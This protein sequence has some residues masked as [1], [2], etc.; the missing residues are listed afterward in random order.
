MELPKNYD[1][2][3]EEPRWQK[4]W[5]EKDIFVFDPK[6]Q[7][8]AYTIDTPPP[9]VSG[10][11]HLGHAF[12]Y[13]QEDFIAR[14]Q[15]MRGKNVYYPFGTDDNGLPTERLIE[16]L[17]K[18]KSTKMER[19]EF[20]EL[21]YKTIKEI[22]P[23]FI[24]GWIDI[25]MS[26]DFKGTYSTIDPHCQKTSQASFLDLFNKGKVHR[27]ET[28][29]TWC[30]NCQTAIAQAEFEN[31]DMTSHF[32]DIIFKCK[33]KELIIATTRPELLPACVGLFYHPD[34]DRY[35]DL[36]G[37]FATVPLFDYEVPILQ[38]ASVAKDVGTGLMMVCTFGDKEDVEKWHKYH[39]AL[40][41]V[42]TKDGKL[43]ELT[44]KYAG[45][46]IKEGRKNILADLKESQLLKN[47][48]QIS[49]AV[50]VHDKCGTE[51]EFLKTPQW[52]IKVLD[53]KEELIEA[54]DKMTW[55]P[56]HMKVRYLHWVENLNWDWC[57]SRQRHF[58]VPFPLWYCK[59]CRAPK[60]AE[61]KDLPVDPL[62]KK[63]DSPCKCGSAD[64]EPEHDVMDTWA[65]SSVTPQIILNWKSKSKYDADFKHYPTS[66]RPQA[67]DIIRTWAFY[68][69]VKGLYNCDNI[70]WTNIM[71]SGHAQDPHGRKMSKSKGNVIDPA[72]MIEKYSSDALRF[73]AASSK[74]GE[75]L[76]FQEKDLVTGQKMITKMW[77]ASKFSIMHLEDYEKKPIKC[78]DLEVIDKW[79]LSKL[80]RIIK[81]CTDM[82]E[83]YEYSRTKQEVE[84]FFWN[85]FCD[86]YLEII[87]ERL[88]NPDRRGKDA[89]TSAQQILYE[90]VLSVIKMIAP[91]MPHITES[92]YQ[93]YF[94]EKE[95]KESVH[96]SDWPEFKKE[97]LDEEAELAGDLAVNVISAVRKFKSENK[98]SL[99]KDAKLLKIGCDD[100]Q[101]KML[102]SLL[103]DLKATTRAQEVTFEKGDIKTEKFDMTVSL[104]LAE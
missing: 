11:I 81:E 38:D 43:N 67:H 58:G 82:F 69:I 25:G 47:Q 10:K 28:P 35:K 31:V 22:Q 7:K 23:D 91:I 62:M 103:D 90:S 30:V 88:Y 87:K 66:L 20:V 1:P 56:K 46:G 37:K 73:W 84:Q 18:V 13:A 48:E 45:L 4:Y 6:S 34:D 2:Q 83:K 12:S 96:I 71:I 27:E 29:I 14:F 49:H 3:V 98:V 51:I 54:A 77:N 15:R 52:Y 89:R 21:C 64:F 92:I 68:T 85:T 26:C 9:T 42:I 8:Q 24:Q 40:R 76:P 41:M 44:G 99:K 39:L 19:S 100:K 32:S 101:K 33:G 97:Y 78:D 60:V 55:Y 93:I 94:A 50:N 75:D 5:Q 104:E 70:P 74:L 59:K 16:K 65:T 95:K 17:K 72:Q 57:I 102:E 80:H 61:E 53:K 86:N 36:K 63:P 79:L